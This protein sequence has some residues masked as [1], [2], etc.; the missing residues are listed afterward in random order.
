MAESS[1]NA[2]PKVARWHDSNQKCGFKFLVTQIMG[3]LT[4]GP[5]RYT[6]RPM[7]EAHKHLAIS[8]A[9]WQAFMNDA[10]KS[11]EDLAVGAE[12]KTKLLSIISSFQAQCVVKPGEAV[13]EDPGNIKPTSCN[14]TLYHRLGGVYPIAQFVDRLVGMVLTGESVQIDVGQLEGTTQVRHAPGLRY[15]LTEL[16]CNG[17]GGPEVVTSKGFEEAKL[18]VAQEEWPAFLALVAQAA[19]IWP[20]QHLRNALISVMNDLKADICLGMVNTSETPESKG[21]K[22]LQ[23]AGFDRYMAE[24]ALQKTG[25][26]DAAL[27]LLVSGWV[28]EDTTSP[29]TPVPSGCPFGGRVGVCPF[30]GKSGSLPEGH[31]AVPSAPTP[32]EDRLLSAARSLSERG[33]ST[34]DIAQMLQLDEAQLSAALTLTSQAGRV[35]NSNWQKQLDELLDEDPEFCCPVSMMLFKEPVIAS[36]GFMYEKESLEGLW[37]NNMTSPMTRESLRHTMT[38]ALQRRSESIKFREDRSAQLVKFASEAAAQHPQMSV[39][40]L[41]RATEYLEVLK[42]ANVPP[43]AQRAMAVYNQLGKPIPPCYNSVEPNSRLGVVGSAVCN[44]R[45]TLGI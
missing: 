41:N 32:I 6:G 15:V 18:G 7:E 25:T 22:Q 21:R 31:P 38:P 35:L 40:A 28:P 42:P 20:S 44:V 9:E 8:P 29:P 3:Y 4:G 10:A 14:P 17:T 11:L 13:P 39:E 12:A 5:Q 23:D 37:K 2:N 26:A 36:D 1:L 43:L 27:A 34:A 19:D 16:V 30:S 24:A 33:M 45:Q